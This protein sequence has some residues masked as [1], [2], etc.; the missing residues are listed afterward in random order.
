[1]HELPSVLDRR[2]GPGTWRLFGLVWSRD[3]LALVCPAVVA[4]AN[5]RTM[6]DAGRMSTSVPA[7]PPSAVPRRGKPVVTVSRRVTQRPPTGVARRRIMVLNENVKWNDLVAAWVDLMAARRRH[8]C[9]RGGHG[10]QRVKSVS[11]GMLLARS[12]HGSIILDWLKSIQERVYA[13][14][15]NKRQNEGLFLFELHRKCETGARKH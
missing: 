11:V 9:H 12:A 14:G 3:S 8:T 15:K 6:N 2:G 5:Q 1:M 13:C 10:R 4:A 7:S